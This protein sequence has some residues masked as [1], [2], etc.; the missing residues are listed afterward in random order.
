M[1]RIKKIAPVLVLVLS[2]CFLIPHQLFA[3]ENSRRNLAEEVMLQANTELMMTPAF[4]EMKA[5]QLERVR[6]ISYPGKNKEKDLELRSRMAGHLDKKLSWNSLKDDYADVF[7][8]IFTEEE[9]REL[10]KFYKSPVGRKLLSSTGELVQ[11]LLNTTR[12][13]LV[14]I[15]PDLT[16]IE[17]E[18]VLEQKEKRG[19]K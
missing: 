19:E 3:D 12:D 4:E 7:A 18:F 2:V 1:S 13:Q 9:L 17:K 15:G 11:K 6:A 5:K 14:E 10:S 16:K 8:Q